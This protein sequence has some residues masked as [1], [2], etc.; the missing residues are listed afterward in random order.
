MPEP[1]PDRAAGP[2]ADR[3]A[4]VYGYDLPAEPSGSPAELRRVVR[5]VLLDPADRVLLLHGFEPADPALTWWFTPGGGVEAG[6]GLEAA[7]RRELM[8]ETGIAEVELGPV[9]WRRR[10]TFSFVGRRWA[11]DEWY[12]LGRT[13]VTDVDLSGL[14]ELELATITGTR[15]WTVQELRE[16][17]DTV[18]P[19]GLGGLLGT[20]L[21]GGPPAFPLVL[22]PQDE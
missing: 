3:A 17:R 6:E 11:N 20:L 9:I 22:E 5:V 19:V 7:A 4:A 10:S 15:W 1:G 14:T 12:H 8:E 16:T 18:H 21:E 13:E 2:E